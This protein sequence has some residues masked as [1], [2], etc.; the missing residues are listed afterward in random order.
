MG[1]DNLYL[2]F[3]GEAGIVPGLLFILSIIL[4]LRSQWRASKS[5][6]RDTAA[7]W[8]IAIALHGMTSEHILL[9]ARG[10][11][12]GRFVYRNVRGARRRRSL[13]RKVVT[14]SKLHVA[15]MLTSLK[16]GGAE[17]S[18]LNLAWSLIERGH[19]A[20]LVIRPVLGGLPVKNSQRDAYL[21]GP[22]SAH[23]PEVPALRSGAPGSRWKR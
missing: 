1:V 3:L 19:R 15:F 16:G 9:V 22:A 21:P 20:D 17:H 14:M 7:G 13:S 11:V 8:V 12:S 18:M 4:L 6:D 2:M 10:H 5:L 23:R